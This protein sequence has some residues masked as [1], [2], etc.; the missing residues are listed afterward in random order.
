MQNDKEDTI[1][2]SLLLNWLYSSD[3]D[4]PLEELGKWIAAKT[5]GKYSLVKNSNVRPTSL[6][7]EIKHK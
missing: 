4:L 2:K 1:N 6:L 7:D 5:D 3:K